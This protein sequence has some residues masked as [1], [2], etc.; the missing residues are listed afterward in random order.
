MQSLVKLAA[1]LELKL[2]VEGV[3]NR[4]LYLILQELGCKIFQG[5]YFFKPL[6]VHGVEDL[7]LQDKLDQFDKVMA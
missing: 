5:Y 1:D 4:E 6:P 2:I 7:I 3:E